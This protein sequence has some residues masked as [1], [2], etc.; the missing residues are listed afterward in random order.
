MPG[1][2]FAS[3]LKPGSTRSQLAPAA[4]GVRPTPRPISRIG[5]RGDVQRRRARGK[6]GFDRPR[7]ISNTPPG[8]GCAVRRFIHASSIEHLYDV[9]SRPSFRQHPRH[10]RRH[11]G[12]PDQQS[13]RRPRDHLREGRVLQSGR[14][15]QGPAGAQHHRGG[16]AQ[17]RAEARPDRR[18]SDQRQHRHRP[19]HGLRPE[20][21]SAGRHH[22]RQLLHRAPQADAHARARR[23]C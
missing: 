15:G 6:S 11:A 21:L 1:F 5:G 19:R 13:R 8:G 22:G 10:G 20:G 2:G 18:R 9:G 17:R 16:R 7:K 4:R 23:S 3:S 14:L 12:D